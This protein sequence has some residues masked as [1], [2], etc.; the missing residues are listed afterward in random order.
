M[1]SP[2]LCTAQVIGVKSAKLHYVYLYK[3]TQPCAE[4][5]GNNRNS[6]YALRHKRRCTTQRHVYC[7]FAD[8][9]IKIPPVLQAHTLK[10]CVCI[11]I[12][13]YLCGVSNTL[14]N[15]GILLHF[16]VAHFVLAPECPLS[17]LLTLL[18]FTAPGLHSAGSSF[19][20]T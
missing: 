17:P 1:L 2:D 3:Q 14:A 20:L 4:L 18:I 6:A 11:S 12:A 7:H 19:T 10:K 15:T 9:K 13:R 5:C 16:F 8:C